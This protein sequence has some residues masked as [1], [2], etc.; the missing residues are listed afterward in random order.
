MIKAVI[1]DMDGVLIDT[2]KYL[3]KYWCQAGQEAGFDMRPEHGLMIRS[4]A[5]KFAKPA[6]QEI[7]GPEFDYE[8]I[9]ARRKVLMEK[10]LSC[11]G[12]EKKPFVDITLDRLRQM[13]VKMAVATAT[14][15]ARAVRYLREIG[16]D[17]KFDRIV[18]A[19]M[20]ENGK[21]KPDIYL[22]ACSAIGEKPCDCIAVEDSPNGIAA[23]LAAGM[24]VV[25]VPDL[26]Q[27]DE[28]LRHK[29]YAVLDTLKTLPRLAA[30]T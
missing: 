23:A 19:S 29:L 16:I 26:T 6:L 8:K 9:R 12:I 25:M 4:L 7:F 15:Q 2:E 1:F 11:Y 21:P 30:Q 20:V 5:A 14:D 28:A 3:V 18:C 17:H 13:G 27:P 22:Y 24:K 10:Q